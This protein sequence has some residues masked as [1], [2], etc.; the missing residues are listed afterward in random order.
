MEFLHPWNAVRKY[1]G[2]DAARRSPTPPAT[3]IRGRTMKTRGSLL[4]ATC[5][6]IGCQAMAENTNKNLWR[7]HVTLTSFDLRAIERALPE[8]RH[9][10]PDWSDYQISVI[11][12]DTSLLVSFWRPE[13]AGAITITRPQSDGSPAQTIGSVPRVHNELVV[14]LDKKDLH[15]IN[16]TNVR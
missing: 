14:E 10:R 2:M 6:L 3:L 9:Q 16:V 4:I 8:L 15:V 12:T 11:E 13:D 1:L 5:L 7:P